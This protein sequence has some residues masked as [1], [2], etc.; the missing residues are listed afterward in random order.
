MAQ[1]ISTIGKYHIVQTGSRF[2]VV[3]ACGNQY[4]CSHVD[5]GYVYAPMT[6]SGLDYVT[7]AGA[8]TCATAEEAESEAKTL[9]AIDAAKWTGD[10]LAD[11]RP[12][13]PKTL[14]IYDVSSLGSELAEII[15]CSEGWA[16]GIEPDGDRH[17]SKSIWD[18]CELY[19]LQTGKVFRCPSRTKPRDEARES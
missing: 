11:R 17:P 13:D 18:L 3:V 10:E 8:A 1:I 6:Q 16:E 14:T 5:G 15:V 4:Q 19:G 9:D 2:A 12:R 7:S